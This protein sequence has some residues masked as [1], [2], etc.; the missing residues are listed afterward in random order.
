MWFIARRQL[1]QQVFMGIATYLCFFAI[2]Y[3]S[4]Q[5]QIPKFQPKHYSHIVEEG[6]PK[7]IQIKIVQSLKPDKFNYKYFATVTAVNGKSAKGKILLNI[8]KDSSSKSF[9][10]DDILLIY[11][12][13]SKIPKPLNPYQFDYSKYMEYQRVHGQLRIS[14]KEILKTWPGRKTIYGTAQ[15]LRSEIIKKLEKTQLKT[16]ERAIVQA[17]VLGE[18]K[19]ID[20]NL[21]EDY[22]AAGAVH[23]LAVSGLHV[24]IL[25]IILS[26][27]LSPLKRW[28]YGIILHSILVLLMLWGFAVLSGLSPSVTRA[29]TM[30]SFFALAKLYN[31]KTN[32]LNT[33]FISLLS[34]LIFNPL[35]LFH[36]GF[37]LSYLAVFFI[38]W[39]HPI[40]DRIGYSKYWAVRK[41]GSIASVT[42]CAQI[43][44]FPLTL[45]YFHQFPGLFL[46]TNIVVLPFL[47]ILMCGGIMIVLLTILNSLPDLLSDIYNIMLEGLNGFIQWIASQD[48]FLFKN[49]HF[50][51]LKVVAT[52]LVII[53]LAL[54]VKQWIREGR[55]INYHK[56]AASLV[57][58]SILITVF[59]YDKIKTS[60]NQ[61][62]IF[63]RSGNT[64][65]GYKNG[66]SF[67]LFK[68]DSLSAFNDAHPIKEYRTA[69]KIKN[70]SEEKLPGIF[71]LKQNNLLIMDSSGIF[72]K[73]GNIH[74]V[75]L[76]E[77][78]KVNLNRLI[79]SLRPKQILADGNNYQ[80]HIKRWKETCKLK[81]LPFYHTAEQGA[82]EIK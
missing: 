37:Q 50:S 16:D 74:T 52:Y 7:T 14:E 20:K 70:Y 41:I 81:K 28:K 61:L 48:D 58:I 17:L 33:L 75:L 11:A 25:Y 78:P 15:I 66:E 54:L 64:L 51:N 56:L 59:I 26:F 19:D 40:F 27:L 42:L 1:I 10:P 39:L 47:T 53:V 22:A 79:D 24:G 6:N 65:L 82:F 60:S 12:K 44:V 71:R 43:G 77:S 72:P 21:Y 80:S 62:I 18:K 57:S 32:A 30:F 36:V 29:V 34:L 46:I 67:V 31:R 63:H 38:V 13:I 55:K 45:F 5:I 49:I 76:S 9:L 4:Y 73:R 2:G 8:S 23:I 3:F 69:M 68:N 35:W